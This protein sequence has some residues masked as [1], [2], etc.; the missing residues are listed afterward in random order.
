M[1]G[2]FT[3]SWRDKTELAAMLGIP[4]GELG[5]YVIERAFVER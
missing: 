3:M 2:R 5:D 1:C 4:E